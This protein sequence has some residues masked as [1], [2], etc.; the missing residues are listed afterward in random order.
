MALDRSRTSL[1]V[2]DTTYNRIAIFDLTRLA[3]GLMAT[4]AL[5]Q[6]NFSARDAGT[7]DLSMNYP[8]AL[9]TTPN[10]A[11]LYAA[12]SNNDRVLVFDVGP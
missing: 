8:T 6:P 11:L 2:S 9:A 5:G 10:S 1:L 3:T 7:S 12:D 4:T